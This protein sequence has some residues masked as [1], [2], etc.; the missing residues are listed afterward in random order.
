MGVASNPARTDPW[1]AL[2]YS[3]IMRARRLLA[4][5][6]ARFDA[7]LMEAR[8]IIERGKSIRSVAVGPVSSF[9]MFLEQLDVGAD[10]NVQARRVTLRPP[11]GPTVDLLHPTKKAVATMVETAIRAK[12]LRYFAEVHLFRYLSRIGTD[13][14][15]PAPPNQ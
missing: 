11:C 15:P 4:K 10:V 14:F 13:S 6:T 1:G 9:F 12:T 8:K 3:C 5:S 7:F 2:A